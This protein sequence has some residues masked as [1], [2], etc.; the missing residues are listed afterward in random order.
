MSKLKV[1]SEVLNDFVNRYFVDMDFSELENITDEDITNLLSQVEKAL[2]EINMAKY[3]DD[4]PALW[5]NREICLRT[6]VVLT[7]LTYFADALERN[8]YMERAAVLLSRVVDSFNR[9]VMEDPEIVKAIEENRLEEELQKHFPSEVL[10]TRRDSN[11]I[12]LLDETDL[13][14]VPEEYQPIPDKF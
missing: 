10:N 5:F 9:K 13:N 1:H 6:L 3:E 2:V 8:G 4:D 7:Q 14:A 12:E 11:F